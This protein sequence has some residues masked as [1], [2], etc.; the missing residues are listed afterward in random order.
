[1]HDDVRLRRFLA[2]P[3]QRFEAIDAGKPD[4][5][6]HEVIHILLDF[7]QAVL[8]GRDGFG[9]KAFVLEDALQRLPDAGLV[10]DNEDS[11]HTG[12]STTNRVPFGEFGS[13]PIYPPWSSRMRLEM[14]RPRPVPFLCVEKYG[15]KSRS[16]SSGAMP[17]P[18]SAMV[19]RAMV[20][21]RA[22]SQ[23]IFNSGSGS[24]ESASRALSSR[25]TRTR[26]I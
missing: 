18:V 2:Q 20:S 12:S 24:L 6:Q 23:R 4:V 14:A 1:N 22:S 3:S 26:F 19:N 11:W 9:R 13:A 7:L 8:A 15:L 5:E 10:I 17:R 25:L 16:R 21:S